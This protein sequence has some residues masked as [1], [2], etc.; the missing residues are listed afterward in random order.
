MTLLNQNWINFD[1]EAVTGRVPS[2][3]QVYA[4]PG[5]TMSPEQ[6]GAVA[7]A[8]K[9]FTDTVTYSVD[10]GGYH[11]QHRVLPDK[12]RVR[13]IS[14]Q[15]QMSVFVWLEGYGEIT[16]KHRGFVIR[17]ITTEWPNKNALL[18]YV[19]L[20]TPKWS[21]WVSPYTPGANATPPYWLDATHRTKTRGVAADGKYADVYLQEGTS[22]LRN[23]KHAGETDP[24]ALPLI[25]RDLSDANPTHFS[26]SD[27]D[28]KHTGVEL[29]NRS[30]LNFAIPNKVTYAGVR[31]VEADR[32]A[33]YLTFN[34][35]STGGI[36]KKSVQV[37]LLTTTPW[38][39]AGAADFE[40]VVPAPV[41]YRGGYTNIVDFTPGEPYEG[42]P[43]GDMLIAGK[44]A[45][46]IKMVAASIPLQ[47]RRRVEAMKTE[48][49]TLT[50]HLY[51][52]MIATMARQ[53][54][55][56]SRMEFGSN[57]WRG[58]WPGPLI[59]VNSSTQAC[60][61]G[62]GG[63]LSPLEN[64]PNTPPIERDQIVT[65]TTSEGGQ[66]LNHQDSATAVTTVG[67]HTLFNSSSTH[68]I[69][70]S[71]LYYWEPI[72][73]YQGGK[74]SAGAPSCEFKVWEPPHWI[75]GNLYGG[76]VSDYKLY[77]KPT[78]IA[79]KTF[80]TRID[81]E[82][83]VEVINVSAQSRDY[84]FYDA[85]NGVYVYFA[86][87]FLGQSTQHTRETTS[88]GYRFTDDLTKSI[89]VTLK[90]RLESPMG[91]A[92]VTVKTWAHD[93]QPSINAVPPEDIDQRDINTVWKHAVPVVAPPIFTPKWFDQGIC[94]HIA[95][96]TADEA[97]GADGLIQKLLASFRFQILFGGRPPMA[98]APTIEHATVIEVPMFEAML[99]THHPGIWYYSYS[100]LESTPANL[101]ANFP[102]PAVYA[103]LGLPLDTLAEFYRT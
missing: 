98:E 7:H 81:T 14:M 66:K 93:T 62:A 57:L 84:I 71:D 99:S 15:G 18:K 72:I 59:W 58:T 77:G 9:L 17:P 103:D 24:T 60:S 79:A 35:T 2:Q 11:T 32:E 90:L 3:T 63:Y 95:Y 28:I 61:L 25:V 64:F 31:Y 86:G 10:P 23:T 48:G 69:I 100:D 68:T 83:R 6:Q 42:Y 12:T 5:V 39:T 92:E 78:Q 65:V 55:V 43:N 41:V 80:D 89:T 82:D 8:F 70:H 37:N 40:Q 19:T 13:L 75:G 4:P 46:E 21:K 27:L 85:P 33:Q 29:F 1:G 73:K 67:P 53:L 94:P 44:M 88:G 51:P 45:D 102:A 101:N 34:L 16:D 36:Q 22:L 47:D 49:D 56:D 96:T 76:W 20:P 74:G 50:L 30:V 38:A 87:E 97:S 26:V 52:D 91:S 54:V